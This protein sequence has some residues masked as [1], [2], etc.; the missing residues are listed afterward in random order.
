M[1]AIF[2]RSLTSAF[3]LSASQLTLKIPLLELQ[4]TLF[5]LDP[6]AAP[7]PAGKPKV[8]ETTTDRLTNYTKKRL[9]KVECET[10]EAMD[11]DSNDGEVD[12]SSTCLVE[13]K[14]A[15]AR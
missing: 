13:S 7:F 12:R 5:C 14:M 15:G 9:L 10:L 6:G 4:F 1:K 3:R 2:G 8:T 11:D